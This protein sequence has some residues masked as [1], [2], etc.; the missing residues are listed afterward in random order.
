MEKKKEKKRSRKLSA[1]FHRECTRIK[2]SSSLP[3]VSQSFPLQNTKQHPSLTNVHPMEWCYRRCTVLCPRDSAVIRQHPHPTGT[4]FLVA[5][6]QNNYVSPLL[7]PLCL[8][9]NKKRWFNSEWDGIGGQATSAGV[10]GGECQEKNL[11]LYCLSG[12]WGV[13]RS[14]PGEDL[15]REYSS[16]RKENQF[17]FLR[18]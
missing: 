14:E 3:C 5:K 2:V 11:R 15:E 13:K 6:V 12:A 8:D 17:G 18:N 4:Y 10:Q 7:I 9:E 1:R 16:K